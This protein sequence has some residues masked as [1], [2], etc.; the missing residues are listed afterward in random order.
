ML[1]IYIL[2]NSK[3]TQDYYLYNI[4]P[5]LVYFEHNTLQLLSQ[6]GHIFT[7]YYYQ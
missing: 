4:N 2:Y 7:E 3:C 1:D 5:L 6:C